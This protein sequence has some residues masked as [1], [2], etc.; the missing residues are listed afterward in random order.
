MEPWRTPALYA[1]PRSGFHFERVH[2]FAIGRECLSDTQLHW[3]S[4][5]SHHHLSNCVMAPPHLGRLVTPRECFS[6]PPM[7][8]LDVTSQVELPTALQAALVEQRLLSTGYNRSIR[9]HRSIRPYD[10][11]RLLL[12]LLSLLGTPKTSQNKYNMTRTF[13]CC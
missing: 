7:P 6:L 4:C 11:I 12:P 3:V 2:L 10:S 13:Q 8:E 9:L 1:S 5:T